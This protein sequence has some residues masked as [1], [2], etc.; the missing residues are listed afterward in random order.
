MDITHS[1]T[2]TNFVEDSPLKDL[3]KN[4]VRF[5][6]AGKHDSLI[7]LQVV[8]LYTFITK[9]E[10]WTALPSSDDIIMVIAKTVLYNLITYSNS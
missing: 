6:R 8:L 10:T 4:H 3:I 1:V 7:L 5:L 9:I 2:G